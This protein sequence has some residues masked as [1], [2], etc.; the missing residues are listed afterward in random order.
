MS[1]CNYTAGTWPNRRLKVIR[2]I[3]SKYLPEFVRQT[4]EKI[5]IIPKM[6]N[7]MWICLWQRR[8]WEVCKFRGA[9]YCLDIWGTMC[10]TGTTRPL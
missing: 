8:R 6:E 9:Q 10:Q 4:I 5:S 2:G 3:E 1:N 7:A